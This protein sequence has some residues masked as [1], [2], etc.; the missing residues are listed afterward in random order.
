MYESLYKNIF[1]ELWISF[2][3][4]ESCFISLP[5]C[6][7]RHNKYFLFSFDNLYDKTGFRGHNGNFFFFFIVIVAI[8]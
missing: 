8:I 3:K 7:R 6:Q 1:Y 4:T 5:T 2:L